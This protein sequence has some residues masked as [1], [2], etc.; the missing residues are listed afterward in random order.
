MIGD[1]TNAMRVNATGTW[2][3]QKVN[4]VLDWDYR[5]PGVRLDLQSPD[6]KTRTVT[7]AAKN[8]AWDEKT[9]GVF[10]GDPRWP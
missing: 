5:V 1:T 9:P 2:N 7:V 4:V 6:G 10:G 3:G 8:L